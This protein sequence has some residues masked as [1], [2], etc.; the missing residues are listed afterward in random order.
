MRNIGF[1]IL[2][3][4]VIWVLVA[5]NIDTSVATGYGG[6]V[7]NIG[8]MANKQN[9]I[10]IG[11]IVIVCGLIISVFCKSTPSYKIVKCPFCAED[12]NR[13]ALKCKHCGSDVSEHSSK[14]ELPKA[15]G[16]SASE[17]V[18]TNSDGKKDLN[19]SVVSEIAMKMH[20]E[21]PNNKALSVMVTNAP[22]ISML[23][24]TMDKQ[25]GMDFESHLESELVRIKSKK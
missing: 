2:A 12:I 11:G 5:L 17:L 15:H 14:S 1:L 8:L 23:K 13:D 9:Q 20:L 3:V 18:I 19:L 21:M 22:I 25:M 10:V 16:H 4:G 6:R 24:E 7:N